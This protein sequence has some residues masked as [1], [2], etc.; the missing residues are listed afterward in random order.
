MS[1]YKVFLE[2]SVS[3][4][5]LTLV[6]RSVGPADKYVS[7][8]WD[9]HILKVLDAWRNVRLD[10]VVVT[11]DDPHVAIPCL[12]AINGRSPEWLDWRLTVVDNASDQPVYKMLLELDC[13][14][15]LLRVKERTGYLSAMHVAVKETSADWI[16]FVDQRV[17]VTDG[18]LEGMLWAAINRDK[19]GM[20]V[21]W[22]SKR[23]PPRTG[24]SYRH[25]ADALA[26][27][28]P[29]DVPD[30]IPARPCFMVNRKALDRC[31]GFDVDY[32]EPGYGEV[33]DLWMRM[34]NRGWSVVRAHRSYVHDDS[35]GDNGGGHRRFAVRWGKNA[36][37]EYNR[38]VG[39]DGIEG[40]A[41][42]LLAAPSPSSPRVVFVLREVAVCGLILSATHICNALIERG[43]DAS[44]AYSRTVPGHS[45]RHVPT[46]FMP[47]S[48]QSETEMVKG[49]R[50]D[51]QDAHLV[52]TT[53]MT[54]E[55][56]QR[57]CDGRDDL[58]GSYYVQDDERRF[59]TPKGALYSKPENVEASFKR[60]DNLVVN[61]TWVR[62]MLGDLGHNAHRIGIGVDTLMFR[63]LERPTDRTRVMTHCRASTPR[64]GWPFIRAVVNRAAASRD[65]EFIAF[66]EEY[67]S[68]E[69][70][71]VW[72]GSIGRVG[73]EE[74]AR[75][76]GTSHIFLEGS[77]IQGY[78]MQAMEAMS[79]SCALISTDNRGIDSYGTD[80]HDCLVVQ[81]GE[82]E[83]AAAVL[84]RLIDDVVL[85]DR[86]GRQ[87]RKTALGFDWSIIAEEWERYLLERSERCG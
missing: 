68:N 20:V 32:Y 74:L 46:K 67:E 84:C 57:V 64:R 44:F 15:Q 2:R 42:R 81:H 17:L 5:G 77:E 45:L 56:V 47:W 11:H 65:F 87:A 61:S 10:I 31:G 16:V 73:P 35:V 78:G 70:D 4:G 19:V 59:R 50:Q 53:W 6:D 83:E 39:T 37:D 25:A 34:I 72:H 14:D 12:R 76:M 36:D 63:P 29:S 62:D 3:G 9:D 48:F 58:W 22:S 18:W 60:I 41:A 27:A 30:A 85:R 52:A 21:P 26:Q 82:V 38:K 7:D 79:C 49:L 24:H 33:H 23:L 40:V 86:L 51:L 28:A 66:D 54:A 55:T 75:H 80:G 13:I 8:P 71:M 1:N 43:W 69:M